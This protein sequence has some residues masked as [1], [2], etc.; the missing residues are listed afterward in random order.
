MQILGSGYLEAVAQQAGL[1]AGAQEEGQPLPQ[2]GNAQRPT[3]K[4]TSFLKI[5]NKAV[6]VSIGC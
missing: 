1:H 4:G 5:V 2:Y 6:R 3:R